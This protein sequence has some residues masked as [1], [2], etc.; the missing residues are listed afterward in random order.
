MYDMFTLM[1]QFLGQHF[2]AFMFSLTTIRT[3]LKSHHIWRSY[4]GK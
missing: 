1:K 3:S 4:C 2:C